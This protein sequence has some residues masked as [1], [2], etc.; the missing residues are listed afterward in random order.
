MFEAGEGSS[1]SEDS[2]E[3]GQNTEGGEEQEVPEELEN[4]KNAIQDA[5]AYLTRAKKQRAGLER[6]EASSSEVENKKRKQRIE[7]LKKRFPCAK[8]GGLGHWH[9]DKCCHKYGQPFPDCRSSN[10]NNKKKK[11]K[12]KHGKSRIAVMSHFSIVP[13]VEKE[14]T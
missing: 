7:E 3:D 12:K 10:N 5:D 6:Q 4:A 1:D 2:G 11:K 9:H 14:Q 13:L 8:C